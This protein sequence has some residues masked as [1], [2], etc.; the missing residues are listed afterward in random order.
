[1]NR[2]EIDTSAK[3][4]K[5]LKLVKDVLTERINDGKSVTL[6]NEWDVT[7]VK[8]ED[9]RIRAAVG[10]KVFTFECDKNY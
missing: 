9:G 1:M 7:N 5:L 2:I 4:D 3:L 6:V 10:K 8:T